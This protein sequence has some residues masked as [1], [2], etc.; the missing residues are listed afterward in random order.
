[1]KDAKNH[2]LKLRMKKALGSEMRTNAKTI[3]A[4]YILSEAMTYVS[5]WT[6][7]SK[8]VIVGRTMSEW[9]DFRNIGQATTL[10]LKVGGK[11]L[12]SAKINVKQNG[13]VKASMECKPTVIPWDG[14]T[15]CTVHFEL[16]SAD[17]VTLNLEEVDF[18][19]KKV[20]PDGPSSVTVSKQTVALSPTNVE[21]D[22][23]ITIAINDELANYYFGK[24]IYETYINELGGHSYLIEASSAA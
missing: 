13:P 18:G 3:T 17:T 15:T 8:I 11:I 5:V 22:L 16:K 7:L 12:A 9:T 23:T 20:W 21:E 6:L 24:P 1:M 2:R 19:G 10:Y 4:Y 14:S